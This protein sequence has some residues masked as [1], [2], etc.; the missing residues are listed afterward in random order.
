MK[1]VAPKFVTTLNI[2]KGVV[3]FIILQ[4]IGLGI[5]GFYPSLVNYLPARTYLTSHVAPPPMNPKLQH[6]L[7]EYK[8]DIYN[9]KEQKITTAI[10]N[11]QQLVPSNLPNDKLDIFEEHFE[12][13]LGTFALVKK[14]QKT[15]K[16]YN[17]FAE[18]YRE[19][20]FSVRK[21]EKKIRKINNRIEK[22][23]AE[24]RNLDKD[25]KDKCSC[26]K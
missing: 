1:G 4:L 3:P 22:L 16:E 20:H 19:L 10:T 8:F 2:W 13:A 6:C 15:E 9:N 17:L 25:K 5:V 21:I 23:E 14:L 7:Q 12:N 11:F 24:I 26:K 18:D